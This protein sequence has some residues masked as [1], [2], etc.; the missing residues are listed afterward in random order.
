[1][2]ICQ[3]CHKECRSK[4]SKSAH[5]RFCKLNPDYESN[6]KVHV[7]KV[8]KFGVE[9]FKKAKAERTK[10]DPLNQIKTYTLICNKC[11]KE[12]NLDLRIRDYNNSNYRK[13]CSNK[14]A[15]GHIHSKESKEKV[16][17]TL[18]SKIW[19]HYCKECGKEFNSRSTSNNVLCKECHTKKGYKSEN[20]GLHKINCKECGKEIYVKAAEAQYCYECSDKLGYKAFQIFDQNGKKV[21]SEKTRKKLSENS[22]K[23][24]AEGKI[25]PWMSRNITSYAERFFIKVLNFNHI[26]YTREKKVTKYFLDFVIKTPNGIIDLEIDGKQHWTDQARVESDVERDQVL[27]SLGYKVYRIQWNTLN[28]IEGKERMR[29]KI[30]DFLTFYSTFMK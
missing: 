5:E 15:K 21:C 16:S 20:I 7:E 2:F 30:S 27:T 3:Y 10:N 25:K 26:V 24:M 17:Q 9:A 6:I 8:S 4:G 22:K 1:M 18:K 19:T 13:T 28:T 12:Y 11:G 14:C 23:L 29:S